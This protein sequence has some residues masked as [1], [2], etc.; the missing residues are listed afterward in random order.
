MKTREINKTKH[1]S[2]ACWK[3]C[4]VSPCTVY[5]VHSSKHV[6]QIKPKELDFSH[7]IECIHWLARLYT[8]THT[9]MHMHDIYLKMYEEDTS[10]GHNVISYSLGCFLASRWRICAHP[11]EILHCCVLCIL[12]AY[13]YIYRLPQSYITRGQARPSQSKR[14]QTETKPNQTEPGP[15]RVECSTQM[16]TNNFQFFD[17]TA[18]C[19]VADIMFS[20]CNLFM[21]ILLLMFAY[22]AFIP[23]DCFHAFFSLSVCVCAFRC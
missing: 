10:I 17:V 7:W 1:S 6:K 22:S 4:A 16:D 11:T 23:A 18:S 2:C 19:V 3:F 13:K 20:K 12:G 21:A 15:N 5:T 8:Q 9:F 14:N